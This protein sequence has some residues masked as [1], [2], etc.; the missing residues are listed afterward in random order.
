MDG[1]KSVAL[2]GHTFGRDKDSDD[3]RDTASKTAAVAANTE[4]L[5]GTQFEFSAEQVNR[6]RERADQS[7]ESD[8]RSM[9]TAGKTI[10]STRLTPQESIRADIDAMEDDNQDVI[11]IGTLP[12]LPSSS[13]SSSSASSS[14]PSSPSSSSSFSSSDGTHDTTELVE[15]RSTNPFLPFISKLNSQ[16]KVK[17][18]VPSN[19]QDS[20]GHPFQDQD[21][22][23]VL[24]HLHTNTFG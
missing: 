4:E 15:K 5:T 8:G 23:D 6:A 11:F 20:A 17:N 10:D 12:P 7:L 24:D 9:S 22:G 13:E 18:N 19:S 16:K 3:N 1:N 21:S 14:E 2:F